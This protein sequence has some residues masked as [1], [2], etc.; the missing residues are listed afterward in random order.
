MKKHFIL[1][2]FLL[3]LSSIAS[4]QVKRIRSFKVNNNISKEQVIKTFS[5]N[6]IKGA[7][8]LVNQNHNLN[9]MDGGLAGFRWKYNNINVIVAAF[10][11]I[12]NGTAY[13]V[14]TLIPENLS[15]K[16]TIHS[17]QMVAATNEKLLKQSNFNPDT[18]YKAEWASATGFPSLDM[19]SGKPGA[20]FSNVVI[21][22]ESMVK[23]KPK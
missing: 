4:S 11:T 16:R 17:A 15:G 8:Q 23:N 14:W 1:I 5:Q 10:Y 18:R 9:G 20:G 6:I 2:L 13:I 22:G 21:G 19:F 12:Q 3:I 7:T